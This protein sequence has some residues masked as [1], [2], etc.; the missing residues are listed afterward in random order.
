MKSSLPPSSRLSSDRFNRFERIPRNADRPSRSSLRSAPKT[1][2]P[3]R[4]IVPT[5]VEPTRR[6][7]ESEKFLSENLEKALK[8]GY[9]ERAQFLTDLYN[10]LKETEPKSLEDADFFEQ[11]CKCC[12]QFL[13]N[14]NSSI[15]AMCFRILRVSFFNERNL[16]LMLTSHA[17][18]YLVRAIDLRLGNTAE[19]IEAFRLVS[20]IMT[21]YETSNLK[22]VIDTSAAQR[23]GKKY[24]AFP[25][26]IMQP[27]IAIALKV[28]NSSEESKLRQDDYD[29]LATPSLALFFEFCVTEAELILEMAG[30]DWMVRALTGRCGVSRQIVAV[31][32]R[33]LV[34]WLDQPL[35]RERGKL[36]LVLEQIFAPLIEFGFFQTQVASPTSH[37]HEEVENIMDSFTYSFLCI[38]RSWSGLF[39]CAAVGPNASII[40]SSPFR[41]LEYLG[42]G[43]VSDS[44][45]SRLRDMVVDICCTFMELPYAASKFESWKEATNFYGTMHRVDRYRNS[46]KDDFVVAD[47]DM[48]VQYDPIMTD[49][50]DLLNSFRCLAMFI[51]I[52]AGLAHALSRLVMAHPDAPSSIK[53]TLLLSD[54]LR[55]APT[56]VPTSWR[57]SILSTPLLMQSAFESVLTTAA[58]QKTTEN[59]DEQNLHTFQNAKN[60]LLILHRLDQL[61]SI[62]I[63]AAI[64]PIASD[65]TYSIFI[66]KPRLSTKPLKGLANIHEC[67]LNEEEL[68]GPTVQW[69][70]LLKYL[71]AINSDEEMNCKNADYLLHSILAVCLNAVSP[72]IGMQSDWLY[73][74]TP[75]RTAVLAVALAMRWQTRQT[76]HSDFRT[77][78]IRYATEFRAVL[79]TCSSDQSSLLSVKNLLY[80][81]TLFHFA[82]I[83]CMSAHPVGLGILHET[84]ILQVFVEMMSA[85]T[86]VEYVKLILACLDYSIDDLNRIILTKALTSTKPDSRRWATR[87]LGLLCHIRPVDFHKWGIQLL[88]RQLADESVKV[89]RHAMRLLHIWLP[90]YPDCCQIMAPLPVGAFGDAGIFLKTHAY[91][92]ERIVLAD[93]EGV[94]SQVRFWMEELNTRYLQ[95]IDEDMRVAL[96][97]V[98][99]SMDGGYSRSSG[100]KSDRLTLRLPIHLFAALSK[101]PAGREILMEEN[102]SEQL[103][104][105]L[106]MSEIDSSKVKSALLAL[107]NLGTVDEGFEMLLSEDIVVQIVRL[108]E[109]SK[110]LSI[111]GVAFWAI[112][113]LSYSEKGNFMFFVEFLE[114]LSVSG[115]TALASLGW[116]SNKFRRIVEK[117]ETKAISEDST[118]VRKSTVIPEIAID[119]LYPRPR[120]RTQRVESTAGRNRGRSC[121]ALAHIYN[122]ENAARI[123]DRPYFPGKLR[124]TR[125]DISDSI[126]LT[127]DTE[128]ELEPLVRRQTYESGSG[129]ES[130]VMDESCSGPGT[131]TVGTIGSRRR[132]TTLGSGGAGDDLETRTRSSTLARALRDGLTVTKEQLL[133]EAERVDMVCNTHFASKAREKHRLRPLITKPFVQIN[134]N[135][136][137]VIRY[138]YLTKEEIYNIA[139]FRR[140]LFGDFSLADE[141]RRFSVMEDDDNVSGV[142]KGNAIALPAELDILCSNVFPIKPKL[143][144]LFGEEIE[145][146]TVDDRGAKSGH[147]RSQRSEPITPHSAYRCFYCS[148]EKPQPFELPQ[149]IDAAALRREVLG[150]VDM[151]EVKEIQPERKLLSLRMEHPWLFEWPCL[152]ADVLEWLDEYRFRA[153]SRAILQEIFYNALLL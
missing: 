69:P 5:R 112:N 36:H 48:L 57:A 66:V 153:R 55:N 108:A 62:A 18:I 146:N 51:L 67:S 121:S 138:N 113:I 102:V 106:S 14:D 38:L 130:T 95:S 132:A 39:A 37:L 152:Y 143:T 53:A 103:V 30:T 85:T 151:L 93:V 23:T 86:P 115:A 79:D 49:S 119:G 116:E 2:Q 105:H 8:G 63:D 19:R 33:V 28:L 147:S 73:D 75:T 145:E 42:L 87:F 25:K 88:L 122:I 127:T 97:A 56:I 40:S 26:S 17:D 90:M 76:N 34:A 92:D 54:L 123:E 45:I 98:R 99:R 3:Q 137:D 91:S 107:A 32:C 117:A 12:M 125:S 150:E 140:I 78:L 126:R 148:S 20:A 131:G 72:R 129:L 149:G 96:L 100:E 27:I 128:R 141:L 21:I 11:L 109:E 6:R 94:R 31:V 111:K 114:K 9:S 74:R 64:H 70:L 4:A 136:G 82:I 118:P 29:E 65:C 59:I 1:L 15:R 124:R 7:E 60:A 81:G 35:M 22:K 142:W 133:S 84:G 68:M 10:L 52:H 47:S 139:E 50:V 77:L 110:I 24:Y 135:I 144:G 120:S 71:Y 80:S 104:D 46:L 16:V 41:L 13:R 89:V 101:H 44:N 43:T 61:N 134:R 83:G 58:V